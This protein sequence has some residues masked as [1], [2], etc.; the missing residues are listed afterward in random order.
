MKHL[1][2]LKFIKAVAKTGSIR[3]AS[4]QLHITPSALTRKILDF[5]EELGTSIFE[6]L[7]QGVRLNEA[8]HLLIRYINNQLADFELLQSQIS[9][10]SSVQRG[11]INLVC[12]Q[13][14]VGNFVPEQVSVFRQQH[15][16]ITLNIAVADHIKGIDALVDYDADLALL[17]EPPFA[18][19]ISEILISNQSLCA[20]MSESHPLASQ[21]IVSLK[22]CCEWPFALPADWLAIRA[23]LNA[24][25]ARQQLSPLISVESSSLEFLFSYISKDRMITFQIAS[26]VPRLEAGLCIRKID[27]NELTPMRIVLAQLKNRTLTPAAHKFAEQIS[28]ALL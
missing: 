9:D 6:R 3:K 8:G 19:E 5:E 27:K 2:T 25:L 14:F 20:V 28:L 4:D 17:L 18:N 1:Q 12:S 7:P 16:N 26:G 21:E 24:A 15:P 13:A 10:L 11:H 23:N 22:E